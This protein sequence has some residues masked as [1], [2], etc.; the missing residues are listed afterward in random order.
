MNTVKININRLGAIKDSSLEL[1]P[2]MLFSGESG[3]GKSYAAFVIHYL[4]V[5]LLND[6]LKNFFLGKEINFQQILVNKKTG[7]VLL[8]I[9]VHELFSWINRDVISYIGYLV[10]NDKLTGDVEFKIPYDKE[11][12]KFV[13]QEEIVGLDNHEEAFYK[14]ELDDF[15]YR[16]L[17]SS[18]ESAPGPEPFAVLLSAVLMD[19][20]FDDY[21]KIKRTFLMPPSRGALMELTERPVFRSGMY[22]EFFELKNALNR[23]LP[24]PAS[25]SPILLD[26]LSNVNAGNLLQVDGIIMYYTKNGIEIPL[27]AAASSIKEM[28]PFTLF[29]NKFSAASSSILLEEPEAH[30][31]PE[32]QIKVADLIACAVNQGCHMQ[33]TT[34]SDY[35]I[36]RLNNLIKLHEIKEKE[37]PEIFAGITVKWRIKDEYIISPQNIGAY[38]LKR[39]EDGFSR[40]ISQDILEDN[41]IPFDS[42]YQ[43]I[44]NDVQLSREIRSIIRKDG[45]L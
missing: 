38:V 45:N 14:I 21:Q 33:I 22:E 6:R 1:K 12:F 11:T 34:H 4:Y 9:P 10:G 41:E 24:K 19:A 5:L 26:C 44:D 8:E 35:F 32:R 28:A 37:H 42:F 23:P 3:L 25:V 30:L 15:A 40:V 36:K 31:H 39:M 2:L 20:I 43:V 18:Y 27:T 7:G 16:I 13:Y 29:L 17:S